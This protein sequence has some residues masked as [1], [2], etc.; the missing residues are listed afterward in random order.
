MFISPKRSA[1]PLQRVPKIRRIEGGRLADAVSGLVDVLKGDSNLTCL[2]GALKELEAAILIVQELPSEFATQVVR[3][4]TH[5][6][7]PHATSAVATA[8]V[9]YTKTLLE[10]QEGLS[11]DQVF[12]DASTL[13]EPLKKVLSLQVAETFGVVS[14]CQHPVL[15]TLESRL[16][17]N[18]SQGL[19]LEPPARTWT[20]VATHLVPHYLK[21]RALGLCLEVHQASLEVDKV[22]ARLFHPLTTDS[23]KI[24]LLRGVSGTPPRSVIE[25]AVSSGFGALRNLL[26]LSDRLGFT[27]DCV[28]AVRVDQM[29]LPQLAVKASAT[30]FSVVVNFLK[31][32][33]N[34][35]LLQVHDGETPPLLHL[36]MEYNDPQALRIALNLNCFDLCEKHDGFYPSTY[37]LPGEAHLDY[38]KCIAIYTNAIFKELM[39][40]HTT[41]ARKN[42]LRVVAIA[43]LETYN[44]RREYDVRIEDRLFE[45]INRAQFRAQVESI[46]T[47]VGLEAHPRTITLGEVLTSVCANEGSESD[48]TSHSSAGS[49]PLGLVPHASFS[50]KSPN[51]AS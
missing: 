21:L 28:L 35:A 18:L 38:G 46:P 1:S 22:A 27:E 48:S 36:I 43:T 13:I 45:G 26:T 50:P 29:T 19:S 8:F 49:S 41:D 6:D 10:A 17:E 15:C 7:C 51:S 4:I 3:L 2:K 33:R 9:A 23:E 16:R 47:A 37:T 34:L 11:V 32:T 30:T 39:A 31:E 20:E 44:F 24:T 42:L 40:D 14:Q 25:N 5:T 12:K